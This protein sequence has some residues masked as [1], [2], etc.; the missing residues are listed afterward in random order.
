MAG[1]PKIDPPVEPF[2]IYPNLL[3]RDRAG[4]SGPGEACPQP[5]QPT[6][7][8][9]QYEAPEQSPLILA[10]S[11]HFSPAMVAAGHATSCYQ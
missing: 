6:I 7:G 1:G 11:E 9:T 8:P 3:T 5:R 2:D 10:L 4:A